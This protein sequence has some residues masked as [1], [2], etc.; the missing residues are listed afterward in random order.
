MGKKRKVPGINGSSSADIAF[1]LLLFFLLTTS[2][3]TDMGLARKLPRPPEKQEQDQEIDIKKRNMLILLISSENN[4]LCGGEY[5]DVSQVRAKAKEF[6]SNVNDDPNLPEKEEV[7][8]PFFG[9]MM[10][11]SKHVISLQNHRGTQYQAYINVQNE[12]A[13]AYNELRDE[14]SKQKWGKTFA[15]LNPEQQKAVQTIYPQKI[16]EAEP[17]NY[18]EKKTK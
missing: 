7:D 11:T 13:A 1:M 14:V 9:R 8:V 10:V 3:D 16:S 5:V 2:M 12:L 18:G 4:I 15:E 17:K 6:I